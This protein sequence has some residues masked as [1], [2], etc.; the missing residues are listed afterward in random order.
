MD[1]KEYANM[2]KAI[3]DETRLF[4]LK[5]LITNDELCAC[6]LLEEIKKLC[7][8]VIPVNTDASEEKTK[9]LF[10]FSFGRNIIVIKHE[11][12]INI[13]KNLELFAAKNKLLYIN[14][15]KLIYSHFSQ[16]DEYSKKLEASYGKKILSNEITDKTNF[17]VTYRIMMMTIRFFC[18]SM[19]TNLPERR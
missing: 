2:F 10:D 15:P 4:I 8:N 6:K 19:L 7:A 18:G 11:Y 16:N 12:D 3:G 5:K 1:L 14:V 9:L 17:F 13:E